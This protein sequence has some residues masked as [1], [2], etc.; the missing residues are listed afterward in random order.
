MQR[1][2]KRDFPNI[3]FHNRHNFTKRGSQIWRKDGQNKGK[4]QILYCQKFVL[5]I[6]SS[7]QNTV[8]LPDQLITFTTNHQH[9]HSHHNPSHFHITYVHN[10][11]SHLSPAPD[12]NTWRFRTNTT[13]LYAET[14]ARDALPRT[15]PAYV[16]RSQD[17]HSSMCHLVAEAPFLGRSF[18]HPWP[19]WPMTT[20]GQVIVVVPPPFR[21]DASLVVVDGRDKVLQLWGRMRAGFQMLIWRIRSSSSAMRF[22]S[23]LNK[24][25]FWFDLVLAFLIEY[26]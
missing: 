25:R 23:F 15:R 2:W 13:V 9:L 6:S 16:L 8:R 17:A 22:W 5:E 26:Q 4:N 21:G 7:I 3:F 19:A 20:T 10:M 1:M 14:S 18:A 12:L 24:S 11:E